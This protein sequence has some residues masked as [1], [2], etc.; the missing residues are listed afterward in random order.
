[1]LTS[2]LPLFAFYLKKTF[3]IAVYSAY[4]QSPTILNFMRNRLTL[5]AY[6]DGVLAGNRSILSK[7]ITL[8]ESVLPSDRDLALTLISNILPYSGNSLRIGITGVPGV[9]KSTFIEA[10]GQE[11]RHSK[12]K[13]AILAI[14]PSSTQNSG[15]IL[16]D[17]TRMLHLA[18]DPGVFIRP[19]PASGT[20]GGVAKSTREAIL[21]CEAAGFETIII[22]TVGVGQSEINVK[23]MTDIFLL[24]MLAGAGDELQGI[25]RG[26]I[27]MVDLM[28]INKAD[29]ENK[30]KVSQAAQ[31]YQNAL[32]YLQNP[33]SGFP[34]EVIPCSSIQK[35]GIDKIWKFVQDFQKYTQKNG[36]FI[37]NRQHQNTNWMHESIQNSLIHDFYSNENLQNKLKLLESAV[38]EGREHPLNAAKTILENA[39]NQDK[40]VIK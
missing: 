32:H 30:L 16:A 29:G 21:L 36:F 35:T 31:E 17:K 19:S 20:L 4:F 7:A 37:Q 34:I 1:M 24:L 25:K 39:R 11:I 27:E 38:L 6:T 10:F 5:S 22:E 3:K 15:S 28:I 18:S 2:N 9:G 12:A 8:V 14:D 26:I 40:K 13:L 33:P 23:R